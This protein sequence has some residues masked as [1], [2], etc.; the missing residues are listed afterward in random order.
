M[1]A[2]STVIIP[3]PPP[4]KPFR[5]DVSTCCVRAPSLGGEVFDAA[6]SMPVAL[7]ASPCSTL[8][9]SMPYPPP[10]SAQGR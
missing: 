8:A 7:I 2:V 5:N 9:V 6:G 4:P 1:P 10:L 3:P